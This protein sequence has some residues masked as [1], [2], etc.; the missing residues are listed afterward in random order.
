MDFSTLARLR[1]HLSIKHHIPGRIR[2]RFS[3]SVMTDPTAMSIVKSPPEKP[4][5]VVRAD[6]N[7]VAQSVTIEYDAALIPPVLLEE[8][9]A[10]PDDAA[11]VRALETLHDLLY[12]G[13]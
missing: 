1:R 12:S 4:R 3:K 8:L 7:L 10:S 5:G 11:S 9:I 13:A 6:L 2:L